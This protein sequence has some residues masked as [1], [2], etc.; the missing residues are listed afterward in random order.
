M[1]MDRQTKEQVVE[2]YSKSFASAQNAFVLGYRGVTVPEV[3]QLRAQVRAVGGTYEV[4]KN[5]LAT[6][7][8]QDSEVKSLLEHFDGPTAVA[9]SDGDFVGL[10]KVLRD[11]AKDVPALEFRGGVVEGAPVDAEEVQK[12]ADLPSREELVGQLLYMLQSPISRFV[13][14]LGAITP[15]FLRVLAQISEKK[16]T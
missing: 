8:L 13:R 16:D 5:S 7:A 15:Q 12:I 11:F 1:T 6:L 4:L 2:R 10:A 3:T 14:G 9:C